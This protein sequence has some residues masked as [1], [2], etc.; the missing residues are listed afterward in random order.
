MASSS[1][2]TGA[3]KAA[4]FLMSLGEG[5]ATAV[6]EHLGPKEVQ[7]IGG[8]MASLESVSRSQINQVLEQFSVVVQD[9]TSLGIGSDDYVRS[10][11]TNALGDKASG[12]IDRILL[13]R[14][15]KGIEALKWLDARSIADMIRNE[16]P[17]IVAICM[18]HLDPDQ[19]AE[20]LLFL[21]DR[22][23]SDIILRIATLDGVQPMALQELD[24]VLEHQLAGKSSAQSSLIGG[25]Q[26]AANILNYMDG[27]KEAVVMEGVSQVDEDLAERIQELMFVFGN[28]I[29]IDD[30]GLQM[31]MREV[32]SEV[33]VVALKG[34]DEDLKD[35]IFKNMSKRAGEMLREDLEAKGPVRLS[36]V[37]AAQKEILATA[38][39]MADEGEIVLGGA[40][41]E[42]ML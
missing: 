25:E 15:S 28:L 39:R 24:N 2:M 3:E 23:Q 29:D 26:A 10:V 38:R 37:E 33:L 4:V 6:M 27:S 16:H 40:G 34:A 12:V 19:A 1:K 32:S 42:A 14:N 31:L 17:Q 18:S 36:E 8:A 13:G 11:L 21:P 41:G 5:P 9:Q 30:R 22:M 35:K 20:T 7:R